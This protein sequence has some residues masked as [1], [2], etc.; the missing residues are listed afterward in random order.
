[1]SCRTRGSTVRAV[2]RTG[3][4]LWM[5]IWCVVISIFGA[6]LPIVFW[7]PLF[8]PWRAGYQ[9]L[10]GPVDARVTDLM[11][12]ILGGSIAGKWAMHFA[13][14]RFGIRRGFA[15]ARGAM[16]GGL[17]AWFLVDSIACALCGA[18]FN[19]LIINLAT[20]LVFAV[21]LAIVWRDC[22]ARDE[23]EPHVRAARWVR[24]MTVPFALGGI[25]NAFMADTM[26]FEPWMSGV[27][28]SLFGGGELP[29]SARAAIVLFCG[30]IGGCIAAH[31]VMIE[32]IAAHS[33]ARAERWAV[34]AIAISIAIWFTL[35]S[36]WDL[37][38]GGLFNVLWLNLPMLVVAVPPLWIAAR[39]IK[40]SGA[41]A[42][43]AASGDRP[44]EK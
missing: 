13:I 17:L 19:V 6:L 1:L 36:G 30:P 26:F 3:L 27:S 10:L 21:P 2:K 33:I 15:W 35:D 22:N 38:H 24:W 11:L 32:R 29:P 4:A 43:R 18:W 42:P 25:A 41:G 16:L 44:S 37:V 39:E 14:V 31:F 5:E 40:A 28:A 34:P 20:L 7:A 23:R 12:G 9:A 8:A